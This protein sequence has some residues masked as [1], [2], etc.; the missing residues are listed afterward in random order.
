MLDNQYHDFSLRVGIEHDT[1]FN[2]H[3]LCSGNAGHWDIPV[4][5]NQEMTAWGVVLWIIHQV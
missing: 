5:G 2:P 4:S 3:L 1:R